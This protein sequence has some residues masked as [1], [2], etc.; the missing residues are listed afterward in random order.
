M[1]IRLAAVALLAALV[2]V[3]LVGCSTQA[4]PE[5]TGEARRATP[6][7]YRR[8]AEI[9]SPA[10]AKRLLDDGN[11]RFVSGSVLAKDISQARRDEL[12][13]GQKPFAVIVT[14]S[15]SRVPPEVLF[16]QALGDVFVVRVA[17]NVV[18]PVA[19]GSVEYAVEHLGSPLVVVMGHTKCGAVKATVESGEAP[20]SIGS[21]VELIKPSLAQAKADGAAEADQAEK[22]ADAN[23]ELQKKVIEGSRI[24]AEKVTAGKLEII[25]AKYDITSG[26]VIWF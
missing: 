26:K 14:C 9:T 24:L 18:D 21:I 23:V 22:S 8:A 1:R 25:S 4:T 16:D 17:G 20:G 19:L 10:E 11:A 13:Q 5:K 15:D 6:A 3:S 12:A 2:V 7:V